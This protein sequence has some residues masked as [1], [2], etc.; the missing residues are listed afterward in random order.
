MLYLIK[1]RYNIT[2]VIDKNILPQL[3]NKKKEMKTMGKKNK[4]S[5]K[6]KT[7]LALEIII[8]TTATINLITALLILLE[9]LL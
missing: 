4:K 1:M 9:R 6:N 3:L 2:I 7:Q 8:L 5:S